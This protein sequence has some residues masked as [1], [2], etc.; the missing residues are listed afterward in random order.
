MQQT[1]T[2]KNVSSLSERLS[3][4]IEEDQKRILHLTEKKLERLATDSTRSLSE[5]LNTT[6]SDTQYRLKALRKQALMLS[7]MSMLLLT[8]LVI[9]VISGLGIYTNWRLREVKALQAKESAARAE[10]QS[11]PPE[12]VVFRSRGAWYLAARK[13]SYQRLTGTVSGRR[14]DVV[15][16]G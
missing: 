9:V 5:S 15:K 11:L 14:E 7:G 2:Q 8:V 3:Q 12:F 10:L 1:S 6:I 13:I 16:I 4:K